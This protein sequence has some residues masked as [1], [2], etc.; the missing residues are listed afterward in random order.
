MFYH[1]IKR[2]IEAGQ[3]VPGL[4]IGKNVQIADNACFLLKDEHPIQISDDVTIHNGVT[5]YW[6][7]K[8]GKGTRIF[9][10]AGLREFSEIGENTIFGSL[11]FCEGRTKIGSHVS[12]TSQCHITAKAIIEDHV[13]MGPGTVTTNTKRI[14]HGRNYELIEKGPILKKACRIGGGVTI[15]PQVTIGEDALVAAGAV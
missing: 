5:I 10:N 7:T 6:G 2:K 4:I 8:I 14:V 1:E 9:H 15:I 12:I 3:D 11:C 13:F